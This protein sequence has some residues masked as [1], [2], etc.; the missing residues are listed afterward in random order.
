LYG[1]D[2]CLVDFGIFYDAS[3]PLLCDNTRAIQIVNDPVKHELTKHI[4]VDASLLDL[5]VTKKPLLFSMCLL[6][7]S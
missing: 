6:S 4:S 3:T 2:G 5:I 7:C 1:F